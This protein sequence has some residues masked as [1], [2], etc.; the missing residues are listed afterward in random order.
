MYTRTHFPG[1]PSVKACDTAEDE[2]KG[3]PQEQKE[4]I[5]N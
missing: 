1:P 3:K 4:Q 5:G 2:R